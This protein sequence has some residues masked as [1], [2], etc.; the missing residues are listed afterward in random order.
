MGKLISPAG[1]E[2]A[3]IREVLRGNAAIHENSFWIGEDREL[4]FHYADETDIDWNSQEPILQ[5]GERVFLDEE[6]EMWFQSQCTLHR[7]NEEPLRLT[8]DNDPHEVVSYALEE[9]EGG[10]LS[11]ELV[12]EGSKARS[13]DRR[14]YESKIDIRS[15]DGSDY[16]PIEQWK[17]SIVNACTSYRDDM[18]LEFCKLADKLK[19]LRDG[20]DHDWRLISNFIHKYGAD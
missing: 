12:A 6:G 15:I 2:I 17:E 20:E 10:G 13:E 1:T 3:S 8:N 19:Q 4:H 9:G 14:V 16:V 7:D 11:C 18:D 5:A